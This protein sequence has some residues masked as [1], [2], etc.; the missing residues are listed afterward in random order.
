MTDPATDMFNVYEKRLPVPASPLHRVA[1][2]ALDALLYGM[3]MIAVLFLV[4]TFTGFLMI[5]FPPFDPN[6]LYSKSEY[7][8]IYRH[9][10]MLWQ[11]FTFTLIFLLL[12]LYL[13]LMFYTIVRKGGSPAMLLVGLRIVQVSGERPEINFSLF[14]YRVIFPFL[15][16]P[17]GLFLVETYNLFIYPHFTLTDR[18]SRT[19]VTSDRLTR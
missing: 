2:A 13:F 6:R 1:G 12:A 8:T 9:H 14:L 4:M 7:A 3:F 5:L 16:G 11:I 15:L 10:V 17:A 18:L 19:L